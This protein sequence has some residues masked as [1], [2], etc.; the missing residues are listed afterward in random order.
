[1]VKNKSPKADEPKGEKYHFDLK[2]FLKSVIPNVM[3]EFS[4]TASFDCV[5]VKYKSI[6]VHAKQRS[7]LH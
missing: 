7:H 4:L 2:Y 1:M 6:Q 3:E 5:F